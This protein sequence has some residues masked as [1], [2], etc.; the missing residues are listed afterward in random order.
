MMSYLPK[1]RRYHVVSSLQ[2]A[3][4]P[5]EGA[6]GRSKVMAEEPHDQPDELSSPGGTAYALKKGSGTFGYE[7]VLAPH[8]P[9]KGFHARPPAAMTNGK[10]MFIPGPAC[11]TPSEAAL[12]RAKFMAAPFE[13]VKQDPD[14]A[15]KGEAKKRSMEQTLS[16]GFAQEALEDMPPWVVSMDAYKLW[17]SGLEPP[18]SA[19]LSAAAAAEVWRVRHGRVPHAQRLW[20][21]RLHRGRPIKRRSPPLLP[22]AHLP[23]PG[24]LALLLPG[25]NR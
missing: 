12:R 16:D 23:L 18:A 24:P 4:R 11:K 22:A 14:R 15:R 1:I 8:G 9:W 21:I 5:I 13:I 19:Q 20:L 7:G 2:S 17:M 6:L 3:P 25:L 10:Q